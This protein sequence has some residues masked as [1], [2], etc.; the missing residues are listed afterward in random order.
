MSYSHI[1]VAVDF[2]KDNQV[3]I[4]KAVKL[5]KSLRAKLSLIH[6][7]QQVVGASGFVGVIDVDLAGLDPAE[8]MTS[9]LSKKLDVLAADIDYPIAHKFVV[10]GDISHSMEGPVQEVGVDLIICGHHHNFWSRLFP[11]VGGLVHTS[12][13][14][15]L[16]VSLDDE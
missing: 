4:N 1:L 5:A 12:P 2:D 11:S 14:D 6:I 8:P 9:E 13:V 3:V 10:E 7:N 15:L 16:I